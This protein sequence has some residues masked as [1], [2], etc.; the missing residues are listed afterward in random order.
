MGIPSLVIGIATSAAERRQLAQVLGGADAFVIVSSA[1]EARR[2]LDL[3]RRAGAA[4]TAPPGR[5]TS[6]PD[7]AATAAPR[8][9][10]SASDAATAAPDAATAARGAA[11]GGD[12]PVPGDLPTPELSVDSDRRVLRWHGREVALTPLEHDVL[13]CLVRTPGQVWTHQRLHRQVWGNEHLGRGS[14]LHS[15]V[16][17]IRRKLARL[18]AASTIHAVRGVGFRLAPS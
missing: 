1:H 2:F 12:G 13:L 6:A 7:D 3:V 8:A 5:A 11:A 17:R 4:A 18:G 10:T 9:A 16:R 15:V 14:D